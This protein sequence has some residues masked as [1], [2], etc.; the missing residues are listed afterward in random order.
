MAFFVTITFDLKA[1]KSADYINIQNDLDAIDLSKYLTGKRKEVQL[2]ANTYAAKFDDDDFDKPTELRNYLIDEVIRIFKDNNL[3][4][5]YFI[6]VGAKWAWKV[7]N[8]T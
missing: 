1:A 6:N 8:V 4:G 7:G 2:P 3:S 5:K